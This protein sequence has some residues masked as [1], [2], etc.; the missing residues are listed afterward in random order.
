MYGAYDEPVQTA[1]LVHNL[2]HGAI[3]ILYGSRVPAAT[4]AELRRFTDAHQNGTILAPYPKLEDRIALGA[5]VAQGDRL[6]VSSDDGSGVLAT[7]RAFD[8]DAFEAFFD[9]FQFR[10]PESAF[11]RPSDMEP[12]ES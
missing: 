2:E 6:S 3:Y 10:G 1:R 9:A 8:R 5:W 4:V 12:G 7:C 11:I